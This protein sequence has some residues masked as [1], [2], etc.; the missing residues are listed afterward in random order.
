MKIDGSNYCMPA[1]A[2]NMEL[3]V[4]TQRLCPSQILEPLSTHRGQEGSKN[5]D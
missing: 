2:D 5:Y 4:D 1:M 3:K